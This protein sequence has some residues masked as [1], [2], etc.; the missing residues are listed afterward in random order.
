MGAAMTIEARKATMLNEKKE[1]ECIVVEFVNMFV[2][3]E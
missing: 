2:E 1:I 3:K